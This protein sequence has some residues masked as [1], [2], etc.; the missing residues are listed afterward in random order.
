MEDALEARAT[1][2]SLVRY[3]VSI[4]I[5]MEDALEETPAQVLSR[6]GEFQSLF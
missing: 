5:L 3:P 1:M 2:Y 6:I 4:L